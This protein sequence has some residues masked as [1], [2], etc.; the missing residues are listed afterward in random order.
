MYKYRLHYLL[1]QLSVEDYEIAMIFFPE[2]L[3]I[4]KSTWIKWIYIKKNE[5]REI[6]QEALKVIATFFE[7]TI[8]Q[9]ISQKTEK[10]LKT[11]FK[12]F[13]NYLKQKS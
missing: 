10:K 2:A 7:C 3:N 1:R 5:P 12:K 13:K 9:L 11:D 8:D 4:S 6:N